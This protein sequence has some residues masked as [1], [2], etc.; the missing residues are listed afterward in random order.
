MHERLEAELARR[1][2]AGRHCCSPPATRPT[3]ACWARSRGCAAD[4]VDLLRRAEPRLDHRRLPPVPR[5]GRRVPPRAISQHLSE[6]LDGAAARPSI[7]VT[8]SVFSMDGDLA[9]L[10]GLGGAVRRRTTHCSSSTRRT[11]CWPRPRPPARSWSAR[12]P[13]HSARSAGSSLAD[14]AVVDLCRNAARSFIFTTAGA[15]GRRCCGARR[16][17]GARAPTRA[18]RWS[19]SC[20]RTSS[21]LAPGARVADPPHRAGLRGT[22]GTV[23]GALLDRGLLVPA[24]R[25]PTVA[26]GTCRLRIAL[27]AP[28][29][30][31]SSSTCCAH[32]LEDL[33][34]TW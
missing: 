12:C 22:G 7:V 2:G 23:A 17:A 32:A 14:A 10:D 5:R 31:T 29:T 9:P 6:L 13:R 33:E 4:T 28:P 20:G 24:I 34:V 21:A 16:A 3:W 30:P 15:P 26:P 1:C 18:P 25:P 19:H 27:S 11:R 8:D